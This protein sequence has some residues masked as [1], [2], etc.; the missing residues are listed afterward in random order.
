MIKRRSVLQG[1][2]A[3]LLAQQLPL[4]AQAQTAFT[5]TDLGNG[6]SLI[7]GAGSNVVVDA[8]SSELVIAGGGHPEH[9]QALLAEIEKLKPSPRIAALYNLN[10]RRENCGLN[11]VLGPRGT[12]IYAHENTRLW[13]NAEF[14]SKWENTEYTPWPKEYQANQTFYKTSK[15]VLG[16]KSITHGIIGQCTTDGD[17]YVHF[18]HADVLVVGDMLSVGTYPLLDYVTGGWINGAQKTN[19]ALL[20]LVTGTTKVIASQGGVYGKAELEA[21]GALLDHAY[22]EVAKAFQTGRSLADFLA[23]DPMKD[24]RATHGDP[25]LFLTLLYEGTWYHVPGRAVRNII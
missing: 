4:S 17:I 12:P 15:L 10:W 20:G 5:R 23:A 8:G 22:A 1:L 25:T 16:D 7:S 2:G 24:Y 19:T 14:L 18:P 11:T 6:L 13:Q 9:A 3:A 21:Q